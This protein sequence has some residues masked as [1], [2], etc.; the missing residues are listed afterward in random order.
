MHPAQSRIIEMNDHEGNLVRDYD[1]VKQIIVNFY[2]HLFSALEESPLIEKKVEQLV[3]R[4]ITDNEV[5]MLCRPVTERE[6]EDTMMSIKR[7]KVPGPDGFTSEFYRESW[8]T[9]KESVVEAVKTFFAIVHMPR[10]FN[11][12]IISLIPKLEIFMSCYEGTQVP[13][14]VIELIKAY[15]STALFYVKVNGSLQGDFRST[16]G[17]WQG[18]PLSPYLFIIVMDCFTELLQAQGSVTTEGAMRVIRKVLKDFGDISGLHPNLCKSTCYF[19]S[20]EDQEAN[21]F[22]GILGIPIA[23]LLVSNK[24]ALWVK[25][26][27]TFRLKGHSVW[28]VKFKE[29]ISSSM[30]MKVNNGRRVNYLF[31]NWH[32]R[33]IPAE[34]LSKRSI[35]GLRIGVTNTVAQVLETIRWPNGRGLTADMQLLK[36]IFP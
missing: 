3:K 22:S 19:A 14:E 1:G 33:G 28:E 2:T 18:D 30:K 8:Q 4:S 7:G 26:I 16:R 11:R 21:R 6:I 35:S 10:Y 25:W 12:T 20:I 32:R 27:N 5:E 17:L 31:D 23:E 36:M 29:T 9:V 24:E 15:V 13:R 34:F